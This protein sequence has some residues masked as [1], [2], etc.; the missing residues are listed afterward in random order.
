MVVVVADL[1]VTPAAFDSFGGV[2]AAI[3]H[4]CGT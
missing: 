4:A 2:N 3:Q 1:N